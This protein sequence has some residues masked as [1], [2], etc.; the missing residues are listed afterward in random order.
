[1]RDAITMGLAQCLALIPGVSRSGASASA[2]LFV[3]LDREAAF[4][5]SFLLAIPAVFGAG[6]FSLPDAFHPSGVGLAASGPQLL[7]S[8]AIAFVVGYAAIAWLLKFV[9]HHSL[10]WF[11]VYRVALGVVLLILLGTGVVASGPLPAA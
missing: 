6:L 11:G 4:R 9:S 8:V 2:G 10:N 3:G 5:L 1:M 7:V